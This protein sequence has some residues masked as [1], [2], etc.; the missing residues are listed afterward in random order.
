MEINKQ[1][2]IK[3][4]SISFPLFTGIKH[5]QGSAGLQLT[6]SIPVFSSQLTTI[7]DMVFCQ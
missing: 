2:T 7:V 3:V 6:V 4:S 1:V 5:E